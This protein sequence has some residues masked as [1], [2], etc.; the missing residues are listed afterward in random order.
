MTLEDVANEDFLAASVWGVFTTWS[1]FKFV[2]I[3]LA[4][5]N[6]LQ[7]IS[8]LVGTICGAIIGYRHVQN[9]AVISRERIQKER[10]KQAMEHQ[11]AM[12]KLGK[13]VTIAPEFGS[14]F[15]Y[16]ATTA[17]PSDDT[18]DVP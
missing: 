3:A 2:A 17:K 9:L 18:V 15:A 8:P 13:P 16:D 12:A 14:K 4:E 1:G 10:E 7:L 6:T 11:L 5:P